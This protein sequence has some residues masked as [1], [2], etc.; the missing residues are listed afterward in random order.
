M[1]R[2]HGVSGGQGVK[3]RMRKKASVCESY[4]YDFK[5]TGNTMIESRMFTP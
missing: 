1:F 3:A 4:D 5:Q 2:I